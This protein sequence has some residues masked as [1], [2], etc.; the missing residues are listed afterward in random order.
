M[1]FNRNKRNKHSKHSLITVTENCDCRVQRVEP[2]ETT[3]ELRITQKRRTHRK[4][5]EENKTR[6]MASEGLKVAPFSGQGDIRR[7][8]KQIR[9]SFL[10]TAAAHYE[11]PKDQEDA[12]IMFLEN[13]L[14]GPV[15]AFFNRLSPTIKDSWLDCSAALL[16]KYSADLG[17]EDVTGK[18]MRDFVN[19]SQK[20]RS[21]GDYLEEAKEIREILPDMD[22]A[23]ALQ[24][25]AGLDD[26]SLQM[27]VGV[28]LGQNCRTLDRVLD[29][30][31]G[32]RVALREET[33]TQEKR[34]EPEVTPEQTG[35]INAISKLT[36]DNNERLAL[37]LEQRLGTG[38][39][40]QQWR[41]QPEFSYGGNPYQ[42]RIGAPGMAPGEGTAPPNFQRGRYGGAHPQ[43]PPNQVNRKAGNAQGGQW[44]C[45]RCGESGHFGKDCPGNVANGLKGFNP[46]CYRCGQKGHL[47]KGC[48]APPVS[49]QRQDEIR[50]GVELDISQR[51]GTPIHAAAF[52]G[53]WQVGDRQE[54]G[55]SPTSEA[56]ET[57]INE[58]YFVAGDE[59]SHDQVCLLEEAELNA[60]GDRR[61]REEAG[62]DTLPI[63]LQGREPKQG[64][65]TGSP[66]RRRPTPGPFVRIQVDTTG[67]SQ[68]RQGNSA[69]QPRQ[70]S[71]ASAEPE[72]NTREAR[73]KG[74]G[75]VINEARNVET[76]P[77]TL[78]REASVINESRNVEPQ[79]RASAREA[80]ATARDTRAAA[81]PQPSSGSHP[82]SAS[83]QEEQG[84]DEFLAPEPEESGHMGRTR[85]MKGQPL[86]DPV[87]AFRNLPVEGMNWGSLVELSPS[88]KSALSR[89]LI[90]EKARKE[91]VGLT[92]AAIAKDRAPNFYTEIHLSVRS[93]D[94][95]KTGYIVERVLIDGGATINC[96]SGATVDALGL[97]VHDSPATIVKVDG[98]SQKLYHAV[99]LH[100]TV[101]GMKSTAKARVIEGTMPFTLLLGR[102]WLGTVRARGN[103]GEDTYHIPNHAGQIVELPLS[104]TSRE[105][106]EADDESDT[107]D[108]AVDD[109][110]AECNNGEEL[111]SATRAVDGLALNYD[112]Q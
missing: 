59:T 33:R 97:K 32:A 57:W 70:G 61:N 43:P 73:K 84:E 29:A 77:R 34:M 100:F 83:P 41:R 27:M 51:R 46:T 101:A 66:I 94:A 89:S 60:I 15:K 86:F 5:R 75:P 69:S 3:V 102:P 37:I 104:G 35:L 14:T 8:L 20:G 44:N 76:Q 24:T 112:H 49:S 22:R 88:V 87:T 7:F 9:L 107:A 1:R 71:S 55:Y 6:T 31:Q 17:G 92:L 18:A 78:A 98:Q 36:T 28:H 38:Q 90:R 79:P 74:K 85:L 39:N 103:Y 72:I 65:P 99:D 56:E 106:E 54:E 16:E 4:K 30:I 82:P 23:I 108:E 25:I 11:S 110:S 67:R 68:P 13:H 111:Q 58:G 21:L 64:R 80:R 48:N 105:K 47:S 2:P 10:A 93:S 109:S 81:V 52:A 42:L 96:I 40:Q 62:L 12:R 19:L 45:Y 91:Q 63:Q 95:T 50:R 26:S 53:Q